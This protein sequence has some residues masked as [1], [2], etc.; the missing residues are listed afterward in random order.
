MNYKAK[1]LKES[2]KKAHG[3]KK[4]NVIPWNIVTSRRSPRDMANAIR[5]YSHKGIVVLEG[6]YYKNPEHVV[7]CIL[8]NE[9][10]AL[11]VESA[12]NQVAALA[13]IKSYTGDKIGLK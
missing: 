6:I 4:F 13:E 10:L 3:F 7:Q 1:A 9:Q 12:A 8:E 2:L 11:R 5:E